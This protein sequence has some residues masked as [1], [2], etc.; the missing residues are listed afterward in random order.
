LDDLKTVEYAETETK[1]HIEESRKLSVGK[2]LFVS[3]T[4]SYI[5]EVPEVCFV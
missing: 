2:K 4:A 3:Q 1:E 5:C